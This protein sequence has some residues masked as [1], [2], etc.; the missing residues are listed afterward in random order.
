MELQTHV[1]KVFDVCALPALPEEG[2]AADPM[3]PRCLMCRAALPEGLELPTYVSK[4]FD[5]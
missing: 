5:V 2:G 3:C 1:P 4:V